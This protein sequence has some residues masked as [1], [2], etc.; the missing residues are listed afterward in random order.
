MTNAR[1][2]NWVTRERR[3]HLCAK[4][5]DH[6]R[7]R[8]YTLA[9]ELK[10]VIDHRYHHLL[11][12]RIPEQYERI[13]EAFAAALLMPRP[14]VKR[15]FYLGVQDVHAL[16]R[17]FQVSPAAMRIRLEELNLTDPARPTLVHQQGVAA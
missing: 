8:R 15:A 12:A 13:A 1:K 5:E 7:R 4:A 17:H 3:W 9:H 10:H 14:L 6:P 11:Y 16:A 2:L